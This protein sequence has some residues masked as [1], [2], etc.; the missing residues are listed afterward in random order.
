MM[1]QAGKQG[2]EEPSYIS[3][4][5]AIGKDVYIGAFTYI[6]ENVKLEIASKF[7]LAVTLEIMWLLEMIPK[8]LQE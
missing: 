8:S 4:T 7:I 3:S 5:A 1:A 6:G 2:I